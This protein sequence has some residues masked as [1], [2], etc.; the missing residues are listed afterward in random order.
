MLAVAPGSGGGRYLM[1]NGHLDTV[2]LTSCDG[3]PLDP[4]IIDGSLHGRG[5]YD[6]LSGIAAMMV[7]AD[8]AHRRPHRGDIVLALVADEESA[9]LGTAEVLRHVRTDAAIVCEPSGLDITV[10]HKG[11]AW[12]EVIIHGRAAHGSRPDLGIDAITRAGAFLTGLD[13][14]ATDL[15]T[16]DPHPLLGHG[17]VHAGVITGGQE[18]SSYPDRCMITAE[19]RTLPGEDGGTLR[20]ELQRLL[21]QVDA[22]DDLGHQVAITLERQPFAAREG[23]VI[24]DLVTQTLGEHIGRTPIRR[25]EPFWT[26]CALLAEA[27]IDTVLFGVDGGGAHAA[28]EWVT[29]DSLHTV[30]DVLAGVVGR[31]CS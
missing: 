23:S 20:V 14:R 11:F 13:R 8:H 24:V 30:T 25:G 18:T 17:S 28:T 3:D 6:M 1:L 29:L 15:A 2:S 26:D 10:A 19:R 16:K 21:N 4:V 5:S 7:A 31:Y 12:A 9:S 22:V 27:G